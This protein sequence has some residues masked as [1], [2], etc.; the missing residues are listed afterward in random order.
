MLQTRGLCQDV[1]LKA[2]APASLQYLDAGLKARVSAPLQCLDTELKGRV[3]DAK[4]EA[5]V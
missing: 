2:Y 4:L 3:S 5:R 1:G